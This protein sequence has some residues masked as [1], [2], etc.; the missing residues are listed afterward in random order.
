MDD[1]FHELRRQPTGRTLLENE[2]GSDPH[3]L[4]Q[5]WMADARAADRQEEPSACSLATVSQSGAPAVRIVLL[6][7]IEDGAFLFFGPSGGRKGQEIS[8]NPAGALCFY[9]HELHR[10]VRVEGTLSPVSGPL[11]DAYFASRPRASQIGAW[12]SPQSE[13]LPNRA[14]LDNLVKDCT[15]RFEGQEISRPKQWGGYALQPTSMEFW[16]GR[17]S[18]LHDRIL[19]TTEPNGWSRVRLAP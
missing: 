4:F 18:R 13:V 12:A 5:A 8:S 17:A 3:A 2:A 10:Q 15:A 14:T 1:S 9:W 19:F 6:K 16:Q 11:A 7:A